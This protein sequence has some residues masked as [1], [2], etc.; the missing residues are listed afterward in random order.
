[1]SWIAGP[2]GSPLVG[3]GTGSGVA[4][5]RGVRVKRTRQEKIGA[6]RVKRAMAG[7]FAKEVY[8]SLIQRGAVVDTAG[9]GWGWWV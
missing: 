7:L 9:A 6:R 1:M 4:I 5:V 3:T 8:S 2:H